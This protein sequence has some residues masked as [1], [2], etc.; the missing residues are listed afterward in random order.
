M[1]H[2]LVVWSVVLDRDHEFL[3]KAVE[4]AYKGVDSGH[5]GP[6]GAP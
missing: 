2:L 4:E 3:T 5:G 6:F 1:S